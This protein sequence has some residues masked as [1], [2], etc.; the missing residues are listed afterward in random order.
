MQIQQLR[1][2]AFCVY[3]AA[4]LVLAIAAMASALPL[5]RPKAAFITVPVIVGTLLQGAAALAI[6][7][8]MSNGPL[9]PTTLE[10]AATLMLCPFAAALFVWALRSAPSDDDAETLATGGAYAW[11]RHPIYLAFLAMLIATGMVTSAGVKLVAAVVLYLVGSELRIAS[12]E[13]ELAGKFPADYAQYRLRTR[14]RY[15]PGI[16]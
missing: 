16:R 4:W 14:W 13:T 12:E 3:L 10:L 8:S 7:L 11:L 1:V 6:T 15:L 2:A 9:R 5:R